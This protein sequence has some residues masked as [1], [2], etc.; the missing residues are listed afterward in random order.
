MNYEE[1]IMAIY[2]AYEVLEVSEDAVLKARAI[3]GNALFLG[4]LEGILSSH[5]GRIKRI[6]NKESRSLFDKP[7]V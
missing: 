2:S 1:R 4:E 7:E 5:E 6:K 3:T